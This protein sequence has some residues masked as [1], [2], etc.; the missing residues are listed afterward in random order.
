MVQYLS[1]VSE[2]P[3]SDTL[4]VPCGSKAKVDEVVSL[5]SAVFP[6]ATAINVPRTDWK[7]PESGIRG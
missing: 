2:P 1:R 4:F 3:L 5:L 6:T 7:D